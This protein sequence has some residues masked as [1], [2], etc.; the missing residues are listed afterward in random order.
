MLQK[1]WIR[2]SLVVLAGIMVTATGCSGVGGDLDSTQAATV[3]TAMVD[4]SSTIQ[5]Q[6]TLQ[7]NQWREVVDK[8]G[9]PTGSWVTGTIEKFSVQGTVTNPKGGSAEVTGQGS[10]A[11]RD[12]SVS[13]QV[14]LADWA[15]GSLSISGTITSAVEVKA[16]GVGAVST[17][18]TVEG[19]LMVK[20]LNTKLPNLAVPVK[21]SIKVETTG[22][23]VTVCGEVAGHIIGIGKCS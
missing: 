22:T 6:V 7:I 17:K 16:G 3:S 8:N 18:T 5:S 21:I 23:G 15:Y 10:Y 19:M 1:W 12:F 13:M 14:T 4:A 9:K 11:T 2:L 20:G